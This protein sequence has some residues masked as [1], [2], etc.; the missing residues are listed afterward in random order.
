[1]RSFATIA[2]L[3][4]LPALLPAGNKLLTFEDRIELTRG[5]TAEYATVKALLPR[6]RKPLE[7]DAKGEYDKKQWAE[8]AKE[9]GPAARNGDLV[10]ITKIEI[11]DDKIVL[12]INGGYKGGRKWYQG[13]QIGMGGSTAPVSGNNNDTN[14]PGGTSIAVLF[15]KPLEPIK[16]MEIKK[17]LAPVLDFE[18][19]SATQLYS[20][21]LSP[22]VQKA[23]K[24]KRAE[25]GMD[26]EQVIMALGRAQHRSRETKDGL[27]V[28]DWVYGTPPGKITFVTFNGDKVIKVKDAYAGLG[29]QVADQP[30]VR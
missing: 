27:E 12:Q 25:V 16:A 15:H 4:L 30:V 20:E 2:I 6:S 8:I 21:S 22:E 3:M 18:K 14:A 11:D 13:V 17:L 10:Q 19:R 24:D 5:L 29:S 23:I 7:F 26:K 28:E 1:M 9:S